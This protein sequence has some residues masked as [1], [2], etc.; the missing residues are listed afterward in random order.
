MDVVIKSFNG[1]GDL[2]F[3][4][5]TLRVIKETYPDTQIT[6]NTNYPE[7]LKF[8]PFVAH[9]GRE[10]VGVF[11][12]Y[13]DPIHAKHPDR[14]HIHADWKIVCDAYGLDTPPPALKPEI[15]LSRS[16]KPVGERSGVGVQVHHKGHW[17]NKK[18]WPWFQS[19]CDMYPC[20][21]GNRVE[22][23]PAFD[24]T[25]GLVE[26]IASL[27]LVVCAEGGISHIAR[28]MGTPAIVLYGG[29]ARPEWNGYEEHVNLC[30]YP[31]CGPCYHPNPCE[32][33]FERECFNE[34]TPSYVAGEIER[35][36]EG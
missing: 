2:L 24:T 34:F 30:K 9:I 1:L 3:V 35:V 19:L 22:P 26:H 12:G 21:S 29:F 8:N 17:Y 31:P 23:I 7:L 18:V 10:D 6:V 36:L 14:H 20:L 28:A 27:R 11:L 5:P 15:Y 4:T 16:W 13:D 25:I 33:N 32:G